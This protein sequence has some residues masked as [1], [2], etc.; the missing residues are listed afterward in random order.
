MLG[1]NVP[2]LFTVNLFDEKKKRKIN[3]AAQLTVEIAG[4]H[5]HHCICK[6]FVKSV[7][8]TIQIK[9]QYSRCFHEF[10]SNVEVNEFL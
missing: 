6:Y 10:F 7:F 3:A 5:S 4:K 2:T 9:L 1:V 8:T